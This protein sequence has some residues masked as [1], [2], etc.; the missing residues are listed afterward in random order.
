MVLVSNKQHSR[1]AP[2]PGSLGRRIY[3][4]RRMLGMTQAD[5]ADACGVTQSAVAK[6]ERNESEPNLRIRHTL[7]AQL[8][9]YPH[10]LF[11]EV[12]RASA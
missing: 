5:L 8:H 3:D 7:A 4:Q 6:W 9:L 11:A 1:K 12:E 10:V 2:E